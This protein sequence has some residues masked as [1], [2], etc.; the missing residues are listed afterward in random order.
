MT[1]KKQLEKAEGYVK[2]NKECLESERASEETYKIMFKGALVGLA[3]TGI[4]GLIGPE[5]DLGFDRVTNPLQL[6]DAIG[7]ATAIY[8]VPLGLAYGIS[9]L[10][11]KMDEKDLKTA[12]SKLEELSDNYKFERG[13]I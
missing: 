10:A 12:E 4:R 3:Y 7:F 5:V 13:H 6:L 2:A 9:H 1:N 11:T 8:S